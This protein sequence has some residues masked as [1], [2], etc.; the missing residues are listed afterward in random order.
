MS[1]AINIL[2]DETISKNQDEN[3]QIIIKNLFG[4]PEKNYYKLQETIKFSV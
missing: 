3:N 2:S 4:N 1:S